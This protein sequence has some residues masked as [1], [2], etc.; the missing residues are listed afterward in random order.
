M[1]PEEVA[2]VIIDEEVVV[3]GLQP[4]SAQRVIKREKAINLI[5]KFAFAG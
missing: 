1:S 4:A 3:L 5:A 2:G